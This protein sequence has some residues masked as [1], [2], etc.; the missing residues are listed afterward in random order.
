M[1][2][3][4]KVGASQEFTLNRALLVYGESSYDGYPYR[5]PFVTLHE[6]IHDEGE[7]RLGV[8]QLLTPQALLSVLAELGHSLPAEILPE[9]VIARTSEMVAWWS[10]A[11]VRPMFFSDRGEDK[12]LRQLS[13]KQYPHP[14]LLFKASGKSLWI[15]VLGESIRPVAKTKLYMAPYWNCYDNAVVCTGSMRIPQRNSVAAIP[16]WERAFFESA[17]SHAA[18][19]TKHTRHPGGVLALWQSLQDKKR[20]PTKYLFPV[21]ET[22]EEFLAS[23]DTSYANRARNRT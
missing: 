12:T 23:N 14:P 16:A 13:G 2:T 8:A 4:V 11:Q 6:V 19:V 22:L 17:F 9:C 18:G 10:P 20:F 15:R 21:E 3:Y 5:H 1:N 7:A